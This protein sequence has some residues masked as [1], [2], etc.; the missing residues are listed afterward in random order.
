MVPDLRFADWNALD[1]ILALIFIASTGLGYW[2]GVV[3]TLL[4]LVGLIGGFLLALGNYLQVG[5]WLH[6]KHWIKS[7]NAAQITAFLL[8]AAL[9]IIGA[10]LVA[11]LLQMGIRKAGMGYIDRTLGGAFGAV[12]GYA[13]IMALLILPT[14]VAPQSKLVTTSALAPYFLAVAHDVSFLLPRALRFG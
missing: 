10:Q 7:Q 8:L 14:T 11:R 3:R 6:E 5:A 2:R 1:W 9:V 4:G 12:R 13:I